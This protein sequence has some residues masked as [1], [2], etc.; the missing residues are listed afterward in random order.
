MKRLK[1]FALGILGTAF[2]SV[3]LFACSNDETN[4]LSQDTNGLANELKSRIIEDVAIAQ[5]QPGQ[6]TLKLLFDSNQMK[7]DLV[8]EGIF[9]EVESIDVGEGLFTII[10]KNTNTYELVA[11]QVELLKIGDKYYYPNPNNPDLPNTTFATHKC[12]GDKCSSCSFVYETKPNGKPSGKI[13][14]CNCND[15]GKCNHEMTDKDKTDKI[16]DIAKSISEIIKIFL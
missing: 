5:E 8:D 4:N 16:I 13:I 9:A 1:Q 3:G 2:L 11:F 7:K 14:G 6:N 15:S 10:G 12:N